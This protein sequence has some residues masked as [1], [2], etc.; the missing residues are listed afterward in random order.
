MKILGII[1]ARSGSKGIPGKNIKPLNGIPL[2]GY[3]C[4]DAKKSRLLDSVIV[5]TDS[6]EIGEVA[7]Q[8]GV[9]FP[10]LRPQEISEDT[11]PSV[12]FVRHAILHL[13]LQGEFFDAI[14][15][16]QPT[17]PFKPEGFIDACLSKFI[18]GGFDS[19]VSVLEV[20]HEY[21]PH[22]VF[23]ESENGSLKI[24]TGETSLIPRRQELP[25]AFY[26]D[27]SVYVSKVDLIL[28]QNKLVGGKIGFLLS[29]NAYY[30]NLDTMSDW[31]RAEE[32]VKEF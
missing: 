24:A 10:F 8:Y 31:F 11:S 30:C 5:S 4:R 29:D 27:G 1:P 7:K 9:S 19:L 26:R 22:W 20:P 3:V 32:K 18:D 15:L 28:D 21:N 6:H 14:C 23:E 13:M 12:D 2:I 16:L 25:K 17:S